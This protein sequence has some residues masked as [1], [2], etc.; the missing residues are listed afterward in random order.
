MF[1][2]YV[3]IY[4]FRDVDRGRR[5]GPALL[6][7]PDPRAAARQRGLRRRAERA[8]RGGRARRR[9]RR[10]S[11]RGAFAPRV[12]A[13]HPAGP[14]ADD[15]RRPRRALRRARLPRQGDGRLDRQ[16]DGGA[17]VRHGR[18][19]SGRLDLDELRAEHDALPR[20]RAGLARR[21]DRAAWRRPTWRWSCRQAQNEI[22]E[23]ERKG[24]DIRPHRERMIDE[25]LDD[26]VQ[27]PGRPAAA[28]VR[29]RDVDD[30]LRRAE[31]LDDLPRQADAEPHAD[32]DDRPRQ[33][34]VPGE[35]ERADRR[36]HRRL[37]RPARRRSRSTDQGPGAAWR[38]RHARAGRRRAGRRSSAWP[39]TRSPSS[40][41][42]KG[43]D[44]GALLEKKAFEF[45]AV[46]DDAVDRL[47]V[48]D[49]VKKR[50]VTLQRASEQLLG[51]ST[52]RSV[53]T[54]IR[55]GRSRCCG[56]S[57]RGS[58]ASNP[59]RVSS[60]SWIRSGTF[61]TSRWRQAVPHQ[62]PDQPA[63]YGL[64]DLSLIDFEALRAQIRGGAKA[65]RGTAS[66][67]GRRDEGQRHG[68]EEPHA[69]GPRGAV[70]A[71]DRRVQRRQQEPRGVL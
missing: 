55:R 4:N 27:G 28:R 22:A 10:S 49:D 26:E 60:G 17:D 53:S 44:L 63:D 36:L 1:G 18:R 52:A 34:G 20:A 54:R 37:P 47:L 16:G 42:R 33:P 24:L 29:V 71:P 57:A 21:P 66:S 14:A 56:T 50:F 12:P 7:E 38:G 11:S 62:E 9:R 3:A 59:L 43:V 46:R 58:R 25:D 41:R 61:S 70:R 8:P 30:R 69:D 45:I 40:S 67:H 6:R 35:G 2:D 68:L 39:A 31:L 23:L 15:R 13:D 32:A 51:A 65:H 48:S 64:I 19:G 5:D